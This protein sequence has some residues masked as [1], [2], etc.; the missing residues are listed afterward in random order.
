MRG[1]IIN[2]YIGEN[3]TDLGQAHVPTSDRRASTGC[4][5]S[6]V[7]QHLDSSKQSIPLTTR[8]LS[9]WTEN[10]DGMKKVLKKRYMSIESNHHSTKGDALRH[11]LAGAY[12]SVLPKIPKRFDIISSYAQCDVTNSSQ[13]NT[14][15]PPDHQSGRRCVLDKT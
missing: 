12:S 2:L 1:P 13:I 6:A 11:N 5:D 9:F 10:T 8:T 4:G 3:K 7:Y 15:G 14:Q